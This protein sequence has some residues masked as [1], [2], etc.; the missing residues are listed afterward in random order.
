[1]EFQGLL[2]RVSLH[3]I[4]NLLHINSVFTFLTHPVY[5][6]LYIHRKPGLLINVHILEAL[7]AGFYFLLTL[8]KRQDVSH[9]TNHFQMYDSIIFKCMTIGKTL[10]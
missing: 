10:N 9:L 1:M 5:M 4:L 6:W 8:L 2:L 7:V 3:D